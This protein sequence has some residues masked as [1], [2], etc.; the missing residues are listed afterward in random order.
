MS[1]LYGYTEQT[2]RRGGFGRV[3][4]SGRMSD[5]HPPVPRPV[6][7]P[8]SALRDAPQAEPEPTLCD[9]CGAAVYRMHAVW[10]CPACGYKSDCCGW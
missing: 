4:V 7:K 10:R 9:R 3:V 2:Y 8:R 1:V 5:S 6:V